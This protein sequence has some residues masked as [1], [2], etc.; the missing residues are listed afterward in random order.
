LRTEIFRDCIN[1]RHYK[2]TAMTRKVPIND[3]SSKKKHGP[4]AEPV[5]DADAEDN[6]ESGADGKSD[7]QPAGDGGAQTRPPNGDKA[8]EYLDMLQRL[9]AEFENFRRRSRRE[10]AD[11]IRYANEKLLAKLLPILD[12]IQRGIEFSRKSGMSED[13]L[14]GI[15]MVEKQL[16]GLLSE[17]GVAPFDSLGN[18]FDPNVHEPSHMLERDDVDDGTVLEEFQRGYMMHDKLLRVANVV[19]SRKKQEGGAADEPDK[20]P[21]D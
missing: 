1:P 2:E 21:E 20:P 16:L 6:G 10:T 11:T 3:D 8:A 5:D 19:I 13:M 9:K 4:A 14:K 7:T 18:R 12:N 15:I 17:Y